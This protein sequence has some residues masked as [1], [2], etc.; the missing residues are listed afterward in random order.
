MDIKPIF[1]NTDKGDIFQFLQKNAF[2]LLVS[3]GD[4]HP[5]ATHV[6]YVI[7][8]ENEGWCLYSHIARNNRHV[9]FLDRQSQH[10]FIVK[11]VDHYISSTWYDHENVPT[12]NYIAVHL[13][14]SLRIQ[15]GEEAVD[16]MR[17]LMNR[18]EPPGKSQRSFEKLNP[19][20]VQQ[21]MKGLVAFCMSVQVVEGAKKLS[22]NRDVTNQANVIRRLEDL[23]NDKAKKMAILMRRQKEKP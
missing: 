14:G 2:G 15:S 13:T 8:K 10:L 1:R 17:R 11:G 20:M 5:E 7:A 19:H 16:N 9:R 12:W 21:H 3:Q 23:D 6:P 4:A 22:Q 18:L